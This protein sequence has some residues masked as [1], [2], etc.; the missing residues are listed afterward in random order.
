MVMFCLLLTLLVNFDYE[1]L[2]AGEGRRMGNE[3][4]DPCI[5]A[6]HLP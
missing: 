4:L 1:W 6:A 3:G 2:A 5:H